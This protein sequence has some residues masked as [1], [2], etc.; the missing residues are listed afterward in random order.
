MVG[1]DCRVVAQSTK[2]AALEGPSG[3]LMSDSYD[4]S[5]RYYG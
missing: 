2:C 4:D 1:L 5:L 3:K